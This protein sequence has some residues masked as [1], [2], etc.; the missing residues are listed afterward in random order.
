[1]IMLN[2]SIHKYM[3]R[4]ELDLNETCLQIVNRDVK[5]I[6]VFRNV[7]NKYVKETSI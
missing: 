2:E 7:V 3:K 4:S 1:M 6:N 5:T